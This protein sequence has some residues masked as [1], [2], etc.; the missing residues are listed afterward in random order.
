MLSLFI[1]IHTSIE[2]Q[3]FA[4]LVGNVDGD[5]TEFQ[6]Q[7]ERQF[8]LLLSLQ[9]DGNTSIDLAKLKSAAKDAPDTFVGM[10]GTTLKGIC[11]YLEVFDADGNGKIDIDEFVLLLQAAGTKVNLFTGSEDPNSLNDLQAQTLLPFD[12]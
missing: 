5:G 11:K 10:H 7:C 2:V 8:K 6:K 3:R 9:G 12:K 1:K 4:R